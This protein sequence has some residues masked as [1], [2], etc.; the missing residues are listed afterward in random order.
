MGGWKE[1]L[2]TQFRLGAPVVLA[3]LGM[4]AMGFVDAMFLGRI[5]PTEFAGVTL[6]HT[7]LLSWQVFAM[8]C[9]TAVD[10]LTTRG[11]STHS[12]GPVTGRNAAIPRCVWGSRNAR[13]ETTD[14]AASP[15]GFVAVGR[16]SPSTL[17][18][19][20]AADSSAPNA[21]G[22]AWSMLSNAPCFLPIS[23]NGQR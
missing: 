12:H 10:P 19:W 15:T 8:G 2:R 1:E 4:F 6:G 11:W 9:L 18:C 3:Q 22:S 7:W 17:N 14:A 23:P 21:R 20:V 13:S 16:S 5:S